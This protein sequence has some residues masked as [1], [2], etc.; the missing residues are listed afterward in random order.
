M[1]IFK[2]TEYILEFKETE[3]NTPIL[4][5]DDN[6]EV[7]VVK[8]LDASKEQGK[9]TNWCSNSSTGFYVHNKTSNMYR[10][11]FKDGYK[12]RLTW[13]YISQ[14]ASE[15]G[16]Y[17]GGTHWGQ[18]G[19]V[20]GDKKFYDVVRPVDE[21]EPFLFDYK[22]D[23]EI[24]KRI[25]S[26]P[27]GAIDVVHKYQDNASIE[28]SAKL[29]TAYNEIQKIKFISVNKI[30]YTDEDRKDKYDYNL[31]N[32]KAVISYL[33]KKYEIFFECYDAYGRKQI[34]ID[35]DK[36]KKYFK[37]NS[38]PNELYKYLREKF[39]EF[40][41]KNNIHIEYKKDD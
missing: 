7:K 30:I 37:N 41:K 8:T 1:K 26:I 36:F 22:G 21:S 38:A 6:V 4:Y 16:S 17:S 40:S 10:F 20:D 19:V 14:Y 18:G 11:N 28:K 25:E 29:N 15:L 39:L 32:Y 31:P 5:K 24:I 23:R 35:Y 13:D 33:D 9:D 2:F 3:K 27:Q 34:M 12:L